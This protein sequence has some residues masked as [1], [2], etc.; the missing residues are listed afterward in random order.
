MEIT[1]WARPDP[2]DNEVLIKVKCFGINFADIVARK[3]QYNDAPPLPFIPGYEC[4]GIIVACGKDITKFQVGDKVLAFTS[5]GSYAE[6]AVA[7][8]LGCTK[9]PS[10]MTFA[11][12]A[13]IPV[14]FATA[15]YCIHE[16]GPV[17]KGDKILIHA[18]AGGVGLAAVQIAKMAGLVVYGTASNPEK[19]KLLKE[20]YQV[21]H[22]INYKNQDFVTEIQKIEGMQPCLDIVLDSIGGANI[23]KEFPLVR[24]AGRVVGF[25]AASMGDRSL[26]NTFNFLSNVISMLTLSSIDLMINCKGFVGVNLKKLS[27]ARPDIL[28]ELIATIM[29]LFAAGKLRTAVKTYK[30]TQINEAHTDIESRG[31]TGKLIME[32]ESE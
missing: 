12:G 14:V 20:T 7:L 22:V 24:A 1:Q 26:G 15:Y 32:I 28:S 27:E 6:Y 3:G 23:K 30:W 5:F 16:T 31:T 18:A 9:L 25:G 8:E 29:D 13:S 17:R 10:S 21:D 2:K 4:S 11:E 19:I